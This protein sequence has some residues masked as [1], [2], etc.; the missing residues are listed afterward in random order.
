[1]ATTV[2]IMGGIMGTTDITTRG[3]TALGIMDTGDIIIATGIVTTDM[4]MGTV[5]T[6]IVTTAVSALPEPTSATKAGFAIL[7]VIESQA[8]TLL[9]S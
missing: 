1:V 3:I 2:G 5:T 6:G 9:E 8:G 7:T 4:A